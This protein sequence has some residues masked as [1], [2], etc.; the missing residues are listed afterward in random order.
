MKLLIIY[1]DID[2]QALTDKQ[3]WLEFEKL[4]QVCNLNAQ[5][6]TTIQYVYG[7][8]NMLDIARLLYV[9]GHIKYTKLLFKFGPDS[10]P[11]TMNKYASWPKYPYGFNISPLNTAC[12]ILEFGFKK[13][14][15]ERE[16]ME[17]CPS[18]LR[19]RFA[20]P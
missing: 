16:K 3:V 7:N 14:Q 4:I 1:D 6:D 5:K 15:K 12:E 10:E 8:A 9:R 17:G 11:V 13:K 2:G 18:G 20:K 19:E